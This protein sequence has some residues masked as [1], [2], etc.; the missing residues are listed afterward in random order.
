MYIEQRKWSFAVI[1]SV[2]AIVERSTHIK[3]CCIIVCMYKNVVTAL[4][5]CYVTYM[6]CKVVI[7]YGWPL[8]NVSVGF[9]AE[10]WGYTYI[11]TGCFTCMWI[12]K[13]FEYDI[14]SVS[15]FEIF[16][17]VIQ[18]WYLYNTIVEILQHQVSFQYL[19]F[20]K[21]SWPIENNRFGNDNSYEIF[22]H[23]L[24]RDSIR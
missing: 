12:R 17:G 1:L 6:S 22:H 20:L 21:I 23:E 10:P 9:R 24:V 7:K 4:A 2:S 11:I 15:E 5:I 13:S 18:K 8:Q 16:L 3:T 19:I 14:M